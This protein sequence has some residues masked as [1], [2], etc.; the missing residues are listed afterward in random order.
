MFFLIFN[1]HLHHI[2]FISSYVLVSGHRIPSAQV[3]TVWLWK[4]SSFTELPPMLVISFTWWIWLASLVIVVFSWVGFENSEFCYQW[5]KILL[6]LLNNEVNICHSVLNWFF[7]FSLVMD[8]VWSKNTVWQSNEWWQIS[9][10][11]FACY[12]NHS[13]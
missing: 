1:S 2:S 12:R 7:F 6:F 3:I 4:R 5:A 10:S 8:A 11:W 9:F 13:S